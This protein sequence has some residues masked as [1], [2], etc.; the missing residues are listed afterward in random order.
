MCKA[1]GW[2]RLT[3]HQLRHGAASVLLSSGV[4]LP[5]V[6]RLLGHS[7]VASTLDIYGHTGLDVQRQTAVAMDML[8]AT[9]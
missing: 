2:P 7:P 9:M 4:L 6:S 5:V 1:E 8:F 3:F